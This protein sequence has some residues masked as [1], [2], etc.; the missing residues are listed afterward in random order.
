MKYAILVSRMLLGF[1][2]VFFGVNNILHFLPNPAMPPDAGLF[3]SIL[4]TH[5]FMNVVAVL[6]MIGGLLLMVGRYVP[7]ALTI[8]GPVVVNILLFHLLMAPSGL[9]LAVVV[10]VLEL[11]LIWVYRYAFAGIFT[12]GPEVAG[13]PKL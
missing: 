3:L 10:A 7:L 6:M 5:N 2:F 13:S 8:L 12:A 9:P 1:I 4:A 11:F